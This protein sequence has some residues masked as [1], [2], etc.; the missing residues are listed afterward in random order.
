MKIKQLLCQSISI[1]FWTMYLKFA[2]GLP[3]GSILPKDPENTN[4]RFKKSVL[5]LKI[6][7]CNLG[8]KK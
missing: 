6:C 2:G 5:L 3:E 1:E 8:Q 7:L 4:L